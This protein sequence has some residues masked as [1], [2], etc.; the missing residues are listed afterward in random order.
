MCSGTGGA[1]EDYNPEPPETQAVIGKSTFGI[2]N[3]TAYMLW[4]DVQTLHLVR[5]N[6]T[7]QPEGGGNRPGLRKFTTT[8]DFETS[9]KK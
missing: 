8:V 1:R 9:P 7:R 3:E 6:L 5:D 4:L 2:W